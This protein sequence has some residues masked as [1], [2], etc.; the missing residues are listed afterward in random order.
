MYTVDQDLTGKVAVVTG[1]N[2]GIGR[3]T[4]LELARAGAHV[5]MA[6]RSESKTRPV[7]EEIVRETGNEQVEYEPLDLASLAKVRACAEGLLARD[8]PIHLF[9]ANAGL[10]GTKGL[11]EDGFELAIGVN[12][13]GHFLLTQLLLDRIVESAPA[14]IVLVASRGH[15]K[16]DAVDFDQVRRT[17][18]TWSGFPEYCQSKAMNIMFARELGRRLE[19]TGVTTYS[20][21][22]GVVASDVWRRVPW[23]IRSLMKLRMSSNEEGAQTTLYCATSP[24]VADHTGRYY[25]ECAE[26]KPFPSA[27]DDAV[28]KELWDRSL[29]WVGLEEPPRAV[30][31]ARA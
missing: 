25:D 31:E 7:I 21:H 6:N 28:A 11:T 13:I 10:A 15:R 27:S 3:V 23:P 1:A 20:L 29:A 18:S 24:E 16:V 2:T 5:I 9:I 17:T 12:H 4:A 30:A 14:R 22:P 26:A 19:G 8:L